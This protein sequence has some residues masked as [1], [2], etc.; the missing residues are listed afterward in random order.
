MWYNS[1][2]KARFIEI[3]KDYYHK[4]LKVR[5]VTQESWAKTHK[6]LTFNILLHIKT[7]PKVIQKNIFRSSACR[8]AG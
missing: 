3:L 6:F 5:K 1:S 8:G 2:S 7:K 4:V